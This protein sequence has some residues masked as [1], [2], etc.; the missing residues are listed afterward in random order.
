MS[1]ARLRLPGLALSL[2]LA[3]TLAAVPA[4]VLAG[5]YRSSDTVT[6]DSGET[7]EDDLYV[8]AGTITINGTVNG[9]VTVAG[10]T[11]TIGGEIVGSL[12]V[13]GGTV[14]VLGT[15]GGAVRAAAGT[16]RISGE[17]A[18]DVVV[19]GGTVVVDPDATIG[20]DLAGGSGQISMSGSIAGDLLA[21]AEQIDVLGSVEGRVEVAVDELV[22]GPEAS[23]G[24]DVIYSS[25]D[26]AEIADGATIGGSVERRNPSSD[27]AQPLL[28][29]NPLFV[30]LGALLGLLVLGWGMLLLRPRLLV[31]SATELRT[32]PLLAVGAG[33][34][35]W[36]GQF[37]AL[38]AL[39]ILAG[40]LSLFVLALGGAFL[41]PALVV[42][43]LIVLLAIVAA[44]PVAM[45]IGD[46]I[47]RQGSRYLAYA[48][49]ALIW[50]ALLT[51]AGLLNDG[52]GFLVYLCG[53]IIG[54]GAFALYAWRTRTQPY[55]LESVPGAPIPPPAAPAEPPWTPP[56][57]PTSPPPPPPPER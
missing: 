39:F 15:V 5:D 47:L 38:I 56:V 21:G 42:A 11:V 19:V 8:T 37:V 12:N 26:E 22:I 33:I 29:E 45:V 53:W 34:G 30:F 57:P 24:G 50:T 16:V 52:L 10:G 36:I 9:D 32:R 2:A 48:A 35:T 7:V 28:V 46:L 43:L 51:A 14:D 55:A 49:G 4:P 23:V 18:R 44:V 3:A 40:I 54:L 6:V 1:R 13:A 17:V 20:G 31:G 25:T 27:P 41:L